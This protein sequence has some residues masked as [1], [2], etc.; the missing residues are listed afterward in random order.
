M[1]G[2]ML[3][4]AVSLL[5]ASLLATFA[6]FPVACDPDNLG[7][8]GPPGGSGGWDPGE[9]PI[10]NGTGTTGSGGSQTTTTTT[11]PDKPTCAE[12]C[13]LCD[14]EV[15]LPDQGQTTVELRGDWGGASTWTTPNPMVKEGGLWRS[16]IEVGWDKSFQYK[17]IIDGNW[18]PDPN[19]PSQ[20]D[21]GVGGKNSLAPAAVCEDKWTCGVTCGSDVPGLDDWKDEVMYFVFVDRFFDGNPANN[22]GPTPGVQEPADWQG[23]DWAGVTQKIEEGYFTK[24]GVTVLW[25]TVPM[26]NTSQ[27]GKGIGG[28]PNNY[29][30]YHGYWPQ[31][32]DQAEE[33]F[34][35]MADLKNLVDTAHANDIKVIVDYAMNHVHSSSPVFQQNPDWF[36]KLSDCGVCGNGCDW[37]GPSGKKCWF[38]DYLPDFNFTNADARAFSIQ[39]ALWWIEQTGIDG[40]RLDAV[41]H[42]ENSWMWDLRKA[43]AEQVEA[44]TGKHF[45]TVGETFTYSQQD[46]LKDPVTGNLFVDPKAALTGQFDFP[47]RLAIVERVLRREGT[48]YNL[49]SFLDS[50]DNYYGPGLM[51]TWIGNHDIAR[52]I[53]QAD[54][55]AWN[56]YDG[57]VDMK[58]IAWNNP[59]GLPSGMAPFERVANGFTLLF[60]MKGI[61]LIYYGDEIGLPGAGDP[62]NRRFMQW[63]GYSAGQTYLRTHIEKLGQIRKA[64]PALSK[65]KRTKL[66]VADDTYAYQM[67]DG[68]ETVYVAINRSD[69]AKDVTGLPSGSLQDLLT[70]SMVN[71]GTV[72]VPARKSMILVKP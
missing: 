4:R 16:A 18:V 45:Y 51:S 2:A 11:D 7:G 68:T 41:K 56:V 24:L 46:T 26:N 14:R 69:S 31:N 65:G 36:W 13:R 48:M 38:T 5:S 29:T 27:A 19:N 54:N 40:F 22:G 72:N 35:T 71:G 53:H 63:S 9:P 30:A 61:P 64:H 50:N 42:I 66:S 20:V 10:G 37:N 52:V 49:D 17:F 32:L 47:L 23:G 12:A 70:G 55:P 1:V 59:P 43:L 39:N 34:G 44:G 62:D 57:G 3:R 15:T 67:S 58:S 6:L 8:D 28:D 60:T 21:D 25:I 33:H